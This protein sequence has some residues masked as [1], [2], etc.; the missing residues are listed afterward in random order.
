MD[1]SR[2]SCKDETF[3][4]ISQQLLEYIVQRDEWGIV[5]LHRYS[6]VTELFEYPMY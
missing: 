2:V 4:E 1:I 3:H 6:E 5:Y